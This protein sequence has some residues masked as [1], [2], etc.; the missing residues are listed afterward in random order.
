[1]EDVVSVSVFK[2]IADLTGE[3]CKTDGI[4]DP[5]HISDLKPQKPMSLDRTSS[6]SV[7]DPPPKTP[8]FTTG[9]A[10]GESNGYPDLLDPPDPGP[11]QKQHSLSSNASSE[12]QLPCIKEEDKNTPTTPAQENKQLNVS[13]AKRRT[14]SDLTPEQ[15][16]PIGKLKVKYDFFLCLVYQILNIIL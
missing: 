3:E 9:M 10:E 5:G 7:E 8:I 12:S 14:V 11:H 16:T 1:M 2:H 15:K 6:N 4:Y 13:S